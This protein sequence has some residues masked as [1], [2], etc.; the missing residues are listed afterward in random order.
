MAARKRGPG[1]LRAACVSDTRRT[2]RLCCLAK[3][4][5]P[6][7]PSPFDYLEPEAALPSIFTQLQQCQNRS[8]LSADRQKYALRIAEVMLPDLCMSNDLSEEKLRSATYA[9]QRL[10]HTCVQEADCMARERKSGVLSRLFRKIKS[11]LGE[12]IAQ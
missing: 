1:L 4:E 3:A 2:G 7:P 10:T 12:G 6:P 8:T 11:G 9:L 5:P